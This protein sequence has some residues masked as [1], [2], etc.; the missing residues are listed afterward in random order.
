M[1]LV[2]QS[3]S[4]VVALMW[5]M[6]VLFAVE[7]HMTLFSRFAPHSQDVPVALIDALRQAHRLVIFSGAGMSAESGIP[8][9]REAMHGNLTHKNWHRLKDGTKT[10]RVSGPGMNGGVAW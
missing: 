4:Q 2:F 10:R 3:A 1:S 5:M 7:I 6:V 8:T 9:F